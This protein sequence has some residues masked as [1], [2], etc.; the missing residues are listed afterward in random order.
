[1]KRTQI[2]GKTVLA[3]E[4]EEL[5]LLKCPFYSKQSTN[6]LQS[7]AKFQQYFPTEIE[8]KNPKICMEY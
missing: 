1:M 2:N 7:L 6:L 8:Q 4:L 3:H 5:I